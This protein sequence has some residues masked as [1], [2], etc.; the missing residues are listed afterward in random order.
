MP[1]F[2]FKIPMPFGI[3]NE[4]KNKNQDISYMLPTSIKEV[5]IINAK[6]SYKWSWF[7]FKPP[8]IPI[9]S[10]KPEQFDSVKTTV[11]NG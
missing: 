1:S 10:I 3:N 4:N 11:I 9:F 8:F 7:P 5:V 2:N 6:K